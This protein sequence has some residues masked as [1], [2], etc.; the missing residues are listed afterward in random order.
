[1]RSESTDAVLYSNTVLTDILVT[2]TQQLDHLP[3]QTSMGK[4]VTATENNIGN[5]HC[6]MVTDD[7]RTP[8][9][10]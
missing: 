5:R 3:G 1:M 10:P 8:A 6:T 2:Y 7:L 4:P 9:L